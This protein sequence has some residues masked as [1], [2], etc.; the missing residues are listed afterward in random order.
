MK[1]RFFTLTKVAVFG[2]ALL[3]SAPGRA[4]FNGGNS[5]IPNPQS[6]AWLGDSSRFWGT[7]GGV[8]S[9]WGWTFARYSG[10]TEIFIRYWDKG[11]KLD[12]TEVLFNAYTGAGGNKLGY[13][14]QEY[15]WDGAVYKAG[16]SRVEAVAP[17]TGYA[18]GDVW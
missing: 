14:L 10:P 6:G 18:S 13:R 7:V 11:T 8:Y 1:L 15:Y 12:N 3:A 5:G 9:Q 2:L 17:A 4:Y 16:Q